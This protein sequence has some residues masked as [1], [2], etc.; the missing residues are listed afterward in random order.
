MPPGDI[1]S[2][3]IDMMDVI[4]KDS[5]GKNSIDQIDEIDSL[6]HIQFKY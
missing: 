1:I 6:F 3:K 5:Y 2:D 4:I